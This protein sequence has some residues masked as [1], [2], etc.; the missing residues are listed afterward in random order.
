[1]YWDFFCLSDTLL[2]R[3]SDSSSDWQ[4]HAAV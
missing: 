3:G 2:S 4:C 1:M